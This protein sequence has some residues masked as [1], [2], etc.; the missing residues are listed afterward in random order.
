MV[1]FEERDV[2]VERASSEQRQFML[3]T[4]VSSW[5]FNPVPRVRGLADKMMSKYEHWRP[6]VVGLHIRRGDKMAEGGNALAAIA[7]AR[8]LRLEF[9]RGY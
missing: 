8:I 6:P 2:S 7:I 1:Y 4:L 3:F 5:L 9:S